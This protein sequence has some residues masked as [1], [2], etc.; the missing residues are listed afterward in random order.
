MI[1]AKCIEKFRDKTGKIYGYR[2]IDLNN[3]TQDVTPENLK[4]AILNKQ[5]HVVNLTL[6]SNNR[7]I[8]TT[9][10][11]LQSKVLGK[12]PVNPVEKLDETYKN[13][14][15]ALVYL[16]KETIHMG[17][18]Y[19]DCVYGRYYQAFGKEPNI[20]S[21]TNLDELLYKSFLKMLTNKPS[22][23]SDLIWY[24]EEYEHYYTFEHNIQYE[25]VD[26]INKSNIY[27]ALTL[28]YKY[29]KENKL[30]KK[31]V[32]PLKDFLDR[33]KTT[34]IAAINIGY[35]AGNKYYEFLNKE[36]F[37]TIS[38]D[39][40]TVG[41]II[42]SSDIKEHKEYKGY[43][44]VFHKDISKCGAPR[45][46]IA[47][48]FKNA[49]A[50][51]VQVDIKIERHGYVTETRSCVGIRGYI[52]DV[53]SFLINTKTPVEEYAKIVAD[54][55]NQIAPKLYDLADVHQSL[56]S[57][58]GY[59]KPLEKVSLND[60]SSHGKFKGLDLV[61][62]AISRWTNIRGDKT[63]AKIDMMDYTNDTSF[64][65]MYANNVSDSGNNRKLY[66]KYNGKEI[67][68]KVLEGNDINKVIIL[69]TVQ[70]TG[71]IVNNSIALSEVLCKGLISANVKRI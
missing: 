7:L 16:D 65:I 47:A 62:L 58:L 30:S 55:F 67:T 2:L 66:I 69:E 40:F 26:S 32:T 5:I 22:E 48:F 23:I 61:N 27:K 33:I 34:G 21:N 54:K 42:T 3:Q 37:G 18:N 25:N 19:E 12:A 51:N 71:S 68:L 41:H 6:T 50:N 38:N 15:K 52:L 4:Q 70:T 8:D 35:H 9:E 1:Q 43:N 46:S 11:Q 13:V 29:A 49:D 14:A 56:Y 60:L 53:E 36:S 39:I 20:T 31:A 45:V 44:Y 64:R 63:P 24:W 17:D 10:K 28:V 59:N 57:N